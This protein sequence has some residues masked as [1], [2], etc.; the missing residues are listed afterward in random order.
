M[1]QIHRIS[2]RRVMMKIIILMLGFVFIL[3]GNVYAACSFSNTVPLKSLT[4]GFQAWKSVTGAMAECGK[5][6]AELDQDFRLKQPDAFAAN[7]SLYH[8][9]GVANSTM[10]PLLDAGTIRPLDG[11]VAKYGKHLK[12]QQLI[13]I[14]GK[15]MAVAMMVNAQ[16]L[17]YREDIFNNLGLAIPSTYG[18]LISAAEKIQQAGTVDYPLGGT[19]KAGWN[20]AEEFVN[21][22]LG[23]GGEFFGNGNE[24]AINN[25]D[26]V[27]TLETM[28]ELTRFMDP[29]YLVSDST[30]VQK[31]FQQ[32]KIA[33][34]NLWATRAGAMDDA[35]ESQ[36]IGK[37]QFASAPAPTM[38]N[39]PA[40]T[41]W[42]DGIVIAKN[43]SDAEADAAFRVA[44]EG[45]DRQMVQAHNEDAIWLIDGYSA[46]KAAKGASETASN[47]AVP[48]P[49][50][51]KMGLM[52]TALGN[53]IADFLTGKKDARKA[54][55]D[56]ESAYRT[57]AKEA[58]LMD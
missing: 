33:M 19:Y 1:D 25:L 29:E 23:Y 56:I 20:L 5:L 53:G 9:G 30:Y 15:I 39:R 2:S 24:P 45:L 51:K 31:Q 8:I 3:S 27:L 57:A 58:G 7:P 52:H 32:G 42:W 54:L 11:L 35:K 4:A 46:G 10:V 14:D 18:E 26:G 34:A 37:V 16:H 40:S 47:G 50:S 13:K 36:V 38:G 28:K 43:I 41:L 55:A 22:Y 6:E 48:Y 17:M 44:M 49:A 12:P 21:M